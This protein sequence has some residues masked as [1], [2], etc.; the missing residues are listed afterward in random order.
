MSKNEIV[1]LIWEWATEELEI[2]KEKGLIT[3]SKEQKEQFLKD[4]IDAE[5][6]QDEVKEIK[7]EIENF[8]LCR[9]ELIEP[10]EIISDGRGGIDFEDHPEDSYI[11]EIEYELKEVA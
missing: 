5:Y 6:S 3:C 10:Y 2:N 11:T 1:N 7:K 9:E 8:Y 4:L